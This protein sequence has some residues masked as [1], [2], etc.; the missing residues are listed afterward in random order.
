MAITW[1]KNWQSSDDGTLISGIDL[2]NI[3]DDIDGGSGVGDASTIH[4]YSVPTPGGAD[5][6]KALTWDN[7]A[8]A[9]IFSSL[10]YTLNV[11]VGS[12]TRD[13]TAASGAVPIATVGFQPKAVLFFA[14]VANNVQAS[15]GMVDENLN[16]G[17]VLST[18]GDTVGTYLP[19]TA[20]LYLYDSSGNYQSGSVTSIDSL[21]FTITWTKAGT[22]ASNTATITY[23]AIA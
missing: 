18:A 9:F 12:F 6:G 8:A 5:D 3:Q 20:A 7:E 1:T 22:P 19:T 4:G 13:L 16:Q 14:G 2:K 15:W 17:G 11:T 23:I 10:A 21:G